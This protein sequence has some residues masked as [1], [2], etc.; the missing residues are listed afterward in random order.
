MRLKI[1]LLTICA[2]AL[3]SGCSEVRKPIA[4]PEPLFC[5]LTDTRQFSSHVFE[6]RVLNDAKNLRRDVVE[7][8][9]RKKYC[10]APDSMVEAN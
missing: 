9:L 10:P 8:E 5:D 1:C 6:W 4:P 7:N 3:V 2:I